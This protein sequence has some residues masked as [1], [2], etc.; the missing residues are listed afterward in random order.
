[1]GISLNVSE[2][3]DACVDAFKSITELCIAEEVE[4]EVFKEE[5][6]V[7][8]IEFS[9]IVC[10]S[11]TSICGRRIGEVVYSI[12]FMSKMSSLLLDMFLG[13]LLLLLLFF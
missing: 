7:E 3:L 8:D 11:E 12:F 4:K 9:I 2:I 10:E 1:V 5:E 13:L 6:C